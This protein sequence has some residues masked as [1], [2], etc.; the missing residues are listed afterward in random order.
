MP[1]SVSRRP[2]S[3]PAL[4]LPGQEGWKVTPAPLPPTTISDLER[5]LQRQSAH[6][7]RRSAPLATPTGPSAVAGNDALLPADGSKRLFGSTTNRSATRLFNSE[8]AVDAGSVALDA[9]D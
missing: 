7:R 4:L 5:S 9:I 2:P 3:F 6:L 8:A 1:E